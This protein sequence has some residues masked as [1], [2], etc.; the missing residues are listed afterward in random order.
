MANEFYIVIFALSF[1]TFTN[2]LS[3]F[4]ESI[5]SGNNARNCNL[6]SDEESKIM[7]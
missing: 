2:T 7:K 1:Q 3:F 4:G 6:Q 5:S